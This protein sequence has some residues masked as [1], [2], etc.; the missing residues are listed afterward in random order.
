MYNDDVINR[1]ENEQSQIMEHFKKGFNHVSELSQKTISGLL[2][3]RD[4]KIMNI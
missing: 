4:C 2:S 1:N 3:D